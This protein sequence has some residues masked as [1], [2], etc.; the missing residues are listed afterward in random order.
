MGK[1]LLSIKNLNKSFATPVLRDVSL[2]IRH[3]E[4][5]AIVGENG[6]G[7]STLVNILTG[8]LRKDSGQIFL[9]GIEYEA[10]SPA[11]AFAAGV[12]FAAQELSIIGTLSVAENIGLRKL[13]H[14]KSVILREELDQQA[15]DLM[16]LVG[17]E[18]LSPDTLADSLS[19]A[20]RQLLELAKALAPDCRLLLLDEPTAALTAPQ[21]DHLHSIISDLAAAGTSVL[22]ISHRLDDVLSVADVIS[23]LRDGK[24]VSSVPAHTSTVAAM[25]E[26]M[27]G[28]NQQRMDRSTAPA[29]SDIPVLK[30]E[31]LTT[32]EL[33]HPISFTC[34]QGEII[35]VA[36][37]A[38]SGRS[39]LL[40]A[41]FGLVPGTSGS[42]ARCTGNGE[43]AVRNASHAVEMGIGFLAEDRKTMGIFSGQSVL[44]NMMLPGI[45]RVSSSFGLID[46]VLETDAGA[47]LAAK[48]QIKCHS[49]GQDIEQL[50]GGN[51]QKT[52]LARW[53]NCDSAIFLLDEPTRGVD[54]ATKNAIYELLFEMQCKHKAI[55][56]ASS[57]T[58]ELMTVC[59][60]IL[61]LSDRKLVKEFTRGEWSEKD[62]LEAAFQ[63]FTNESA[64]F[65]NEEIPGTGSMQDSNL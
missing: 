32:G 25:I 30:V 15:R 36:G 52:L 37:L 51:Q 11:N 24:V 7:K 33:P 62:I 61:V 42:V 9:D 6:A 18:G 57:E 19:I 43:F 56:I 41:L 16:K 40:Q 44:A 13:P 1:L 4:I 48:L 14:S 10:N 59:N 23:V 28:R 60:R 12:S 17:L 26:Q 20:D 55:I 39:E 49:L 65:K 3:G 35:G 8:M 29:Q 34:H 58:E 2:S 21:A 5:H 45:S 46:R 47:E 63:E 22:Y 38:G 54:V 31:E 53:L 27:T 64:D 50:S